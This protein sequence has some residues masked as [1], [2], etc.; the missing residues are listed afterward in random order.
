MDVVLLA[1]IKFALTIGFHYIW[2][3]LTI[4]LSWLIVYMMGRYLKTKDEMWRNMAR[5]WVRVFAL[6]FVIGVATGITMEF[7]FGTNWAVYSRY[8][9]DIFGAPLAAEG[10]LS[11]FLESTFLGL[12]VFGEKRLSPRMHWFSALMVAFGA[13]LS[14]FWIIVANSWQQT[15]AGFKI[16]GGRAVLTDFWAAVFNPST[17]PRYLHTIDGALVTGSFFMVGIAAWYLLRKEH[18]EFAKRSMKIGLVVALVASVLQG[19][20]G[21]YHAVQVTRTQPVKLAAFEGLFETQTNAP[22]LLFGIPNAKKGRTDYAVKIPGLLSLVVGGTTKTEVKGLNSFPKDQWP[23]LLL[24]FASF[25]L[26]VGLGM[27]FIALAGLGLI[28][29]RRGKLWDNRLYLKAALWS[30]PLPFLANE[31]GWIAAEVG[32]QPW[33]VQ[34]L[35]KTKDAVSV[36][37]PAGQIL[38]VII[39]FT[40]IYALL[41]G[42]WFFLLRKKLLK[43]PDPVTPTA[44]ADPDVPAEGEEVAS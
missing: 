34:G 5:F 39:L 13:T 4:G 15:P 19:G 43:G 21:H 32:R 6:S 18:L 17:V 41:F 27:Y 16:E 38:A 12:L 2:P 3:P 22:L 1:R 37:V 8:V 28:L 23:P 24:P 26:M 30:I 36:N 25:H 11:F 31:L 44:E 14:G 33:I 42:V 10:V 35:L 7:Q 20:L 9:G 29:L 40:I